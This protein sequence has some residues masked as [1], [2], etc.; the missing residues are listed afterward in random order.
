MIDKKTIEIGDHIFIDVDPS[1]EF[2]NIRVG[3]DK[4]K[5]VKKV[6]FWAV[7]F[8]IADK[9]TQEKLLPVRQTEMSTFRRIHH[10]KLKKSLNAGDIV[11]VKCEISVP[12]VV[13][14]GLAG[15]LMKK[16]GK[17]LVPGRV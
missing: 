11:N 8:H 3:D 13:E 2:L 1:S 12:Q 10:V 4:G 14:E 17:I 7:C 16:R 5:L 15:S 6:D 9:A